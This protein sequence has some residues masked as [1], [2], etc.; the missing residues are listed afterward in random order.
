ML[1]LQ[2][3]AIRVVENEGPGIRYSAM[4]SAKQD[5]RQSMHHVYESGGGSEE[6]LAEVNSGRKKA[7]MGVNKRVYTLEHI[8]HTSYDIP[9]SIIATPSLC[10]DTPPHIVDDLV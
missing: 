8:V 7:P 1:T 2:F 4:F 5:M 6:W 9:R 10:F 3:G